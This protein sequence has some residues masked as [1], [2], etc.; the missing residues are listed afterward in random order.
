MSQSV[1]SLRHHACYS[2]SVEIQA[3]QIRQ[4]SEHLVVNFSQPIVGQQSARKKRTKEIRK[5]N[6]DNNEEKR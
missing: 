4:T 5:M 3:L 2:I 6:E 1:E